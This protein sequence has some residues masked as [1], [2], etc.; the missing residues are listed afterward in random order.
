MSMMLRV[1]TWESIGTDVRGNK[2]VEDVL[3][4]AGLNY[5][6]V[7]KPVYRYER[8]PRRLVRMP[9]KF[10][11]ERKE[12]GHSYDAIVS[13]RYRI[14]QNREAFD[15]VNYMGDDVEFLKAGETGNGLVWIIGKL[16]DVDIL[17]DKFTPHVIF[18]NSFTGKTSI[19]AAICPLRI[20]C[21]NQFAAAF[22]DTHNA[23]SVGHTANAE[24]KLKEARSV[25]RA[26]ADYME[27]L[28]RM[29]EGY[30]AMKVSPRQIAM[31]L[32][33][34]F[35]VPADAPQK[36]AEEIAAKKAK[37]EARFRAAMSSAD[38]Y[39][40]RGTAWQLVNAYTDV[41]THAPL[42]GKSTYDSQ[43]VKVTFGNDISKFLKIVD[44]V[45]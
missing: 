28:N 5:T 19:R 13:D 18:S 24:R 40:F 39:A 20:I 32:D 21:Q 12:D 4:S 26:S 37:F 27:E 31:V 6:V 33:A 11:T 14:V 2:K 36:K 17:G 43:F 15:F 38:N 34:M 42:S 8:D 22:R 29:A 7:K 41:L 44:S 35:P 30:A 10:V 1:P 25:L 45:A 9:N 23:V 16:P 3:A